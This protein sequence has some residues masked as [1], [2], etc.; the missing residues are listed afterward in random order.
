[1]CELF[2]YSYS[3]FGSDYCVEMK[4][5]LSFTMGNR[6]EMISA[7]LS[8][9]LITGAEVFIGW[10]LLQRSFPTTEVS[11]R[12]VRLC[13]G[14]FLLV[15]LLPRFFFFW[16]S[17]SLP[18]SVIIAEVFFGSR[19]LPTMM[20]ETWSMCDPMGLDLIRSANVYR[21]ID[22]H[23]DYSTLHCVI[24]TSLQLIS[25]QSLL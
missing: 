9:R 7:R 14:L 25:F 13:R 22:M 19:A 16:Q 20:V 4:H 6:W 1:M 17:R 15:W 2:A 12:R 21:K 18:A 3:F 10:W 8:K 5:W 24:C 11:F 23:H